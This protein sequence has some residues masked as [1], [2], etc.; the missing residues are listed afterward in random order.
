MV[1]KKVCITKYPIFG[2]RH[3]KARDYRETL[4]LPF[5]KCSIDEVYVE[6]VL[7]HL[8][9]DDLLPSLIEWRRVLKVGGKFTIVFEDVVKAAFLYQRD[10]INFE[11][12]QKALSHKKCPLC[13]K[14]LEDFLIM[15]YPKVYEIHFFNNLKRKRLWDT[16]LVAEK[17]PWT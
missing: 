13:L 6:N 5:K 15:R 11:Q 14:Q 12:L 3:I 8:S 1:I 9:I 17:H 7:E 10:A 4:K 16:I 2:W